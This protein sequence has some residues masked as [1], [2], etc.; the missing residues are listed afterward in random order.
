MLSVQHHFL[1][2]IALS[3]LVKMLVTSSYLSCQ[4]C[5]HVIQPGSIMLLPSAA[6]C[7][8]YIDGHMSQISQSV[9]SSGILLNLLW[10]KS[11]FL[12]VISYKDD[13][14]FDSICWGLFLPL[15]MKKLPC[16]KK[17]QKQEMDR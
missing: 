11:L 12:F 4:D 2:G 8:P 5:S 17:K 15:G 10:K 6:V 9:S 7:V 13:K 1:S 3:N 16:T 14:S